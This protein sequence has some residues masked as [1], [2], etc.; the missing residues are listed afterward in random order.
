MKNAIIIHSMPEKEEFDNPKFPSP[1]SSHW[2]PWIKNQLILKNISAETPEM[3]IP[4]NPEYSAWKKTF[5]QYEINE[6]TILIGHSCGAGFI[7]RWLSENNTKV[8]KVILVAP[9]L[10]PGNGQDKFLDTGMFDF[11][12]DPNLV[13][14]T[15]GLI[16]FSS[17]NDEDGVLASV[18]KLQTE[19]KN[20]KV[21]EFENM[22]HFCYGDMGTDA[23][24]ELLTEALS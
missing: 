6:N 16:V 2:L 1:S 5:E 13:E 3:P 8:G 4:Y 11:V 7:V 22:G 21:R 12:I 15:S 9:W 24:P 10:D 17:T 19:I 14:K 18:A 20:L 23:F